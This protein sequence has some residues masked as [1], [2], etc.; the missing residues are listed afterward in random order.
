ML[1]LYALGTSKRVPLGFSAGFSAGCSLA[2]CA[3]GCAGS[4]GSLALAAS[5]GVVCASVYGWL[6]GLASLLIFC[7]ALAKVVLSMGVGVRSAVV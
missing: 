1:A 4:A 6:A 5:A 2:A 7:R 3:A